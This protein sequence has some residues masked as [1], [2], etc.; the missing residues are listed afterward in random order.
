LDTLSI[1]FW[2]ESRNEYVIYTRDVAREGDFLEGVRWIRRS[3]SKDFLNWTESESISTGDAPFE[4]LYTNACIP[5]DRSPSTYLMF[6]S[7]FVPHRRPNPDWFGSDGVN[8]I[9][10]MSSRDGINFDRS[11]MN[12]FVRPGLD[13]NNWHERAV[14]ME[15]GLIQT[16]PTELSLYGMEGIRTKSVRITRYTIRTDGFVSVNAGYSAGKFTTKPV[17][18]DGTELE[19]NYSTSA[20]GSIKVEFQDLQGLPITGLTL[21]DC[22][23]M[24]GD[25]IGKTI[26][27]NGNSN[28]SDLA[29]KLVRLKFVLM[30][31]D[32]YSFKFNT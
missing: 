6:P 17:I 11:F 31:A 29:G 14:Y 7:R 24:F 10:F 28:I 27:W 8:D 22:P 32:L 20:A 4:H 9:V 1:P 21:G 2:D 25:E 3:T 18:F 15:R 16:S 30:D 12:A 5:Y 19:I 13:Q 23:E 26:N